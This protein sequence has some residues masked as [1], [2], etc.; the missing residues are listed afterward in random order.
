MTLWYIARAAGVMALLA[1]TLTTALGA[2][3]A[4][5]PSRTQAAVARRFALQRIHIAAA[6]TALG[7]LVT[8]LA[9]LVLDTHSG[10]AATAIVVP[11]AAAYRPIAVSLGVLAMYTVVVVALVG[12]TR[13]RVASSAWAARQW[14]GVHALSYLGWAVAI[15]HGAFAGTDTLRGP[16]PLVYGGCVAVVASAAAAR[17]WRESAR[18]RLPL[19]TGRRRIRE[20][21]AG[22]LS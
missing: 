7:L 18:T 2:G 12:A 9:A 14:R 15:A 8:H 4:S 1:L 22:P 6:V 10:I 17:L 19:P 16:M 21:T 13:G 5:R 3:G 11:M 20:S